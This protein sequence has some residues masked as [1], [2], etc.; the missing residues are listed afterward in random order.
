MLPS[1]GTLKYLEERMRDGP[2][3][4]KRLNAQGSVAS[5]LVFSKDPGGLLASQFQDVERN[6]LE[7]KGEAPWSLENQHRIICKAHGLE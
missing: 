3:R 5:I 2:V 6:K 1:K 4:V 7:I